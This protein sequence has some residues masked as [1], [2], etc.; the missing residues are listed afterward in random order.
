MADSTDQDEVSIKRTRSPTESDSDHEVA[1][2][3]KTKKK[4]LHN[5]HSIHALQNTHGSYSQ[6]FSRSMPEEF[7]PVGH[8]TR[9]KDHTTFDYPQRQLYLTLIEFLTASATK[10]TSFKKIVLIYVGD[11]ADLN[12]PVWAHLSTMFPFVYFVLYIKPLA[13]SSKQFE[14]PNVMIKIN[15]EVFNDETA[16]NLIEEYDSN[17]NIRLFVSNLKLEREDCK[18]ELQFMSL[19]RQWYMKLQPFKAMLNFRLHF[20]QTEK[21]A[22]EYLQGQ[23][24]FPIWSTNKS[25][26]T[27]LHVD[28]SAPTRTYDCLKHKSQLTHFYDIDRVQWYEHELHDQPGID[29]CYDCRAEIF[30]FDSYIQMCDDELVKFKFRPPLTVKQY[31]SQLNRLIDSDN[32]LFAIKLNDREYEIKFTDVSLGK[33]LG[34]LSLKP[35]EPATRSP[36][37][38]QYKQSVYVRPDHQLTR[39]LTP[40]F[41]CMKYRRRK[42][43]N[44]TTVHFGQ[45]K[46]L[47]SEI[48]FLTIVCNEFKRDSA[49]KFV[50]VYAGAA[51]GHHTP[52]LMNMFP[53]MEYVLVDPAD[54]KLD[55]AKLKYKCKYTIKQEFFTDEMA[56]QLRKDYRDYEILFISDIRTANYRVLTDKDTEIKVEQ[57]MIDQM[58]WYRILE[59][60]KAMLKFRL[61]Y[62]DRSGKTELEYLKG[63]IYFQVWEG[64]TSSETRLVV[65]KNAGMQVYDCVKYEDQLFRFNTV[66][67]VLCYAHDI[68]ARGIDHC[69][70]CRA[71]I[72][73]LEEYLKL[74]GKLPSPANHQELETSVTELVERI[75][76]DLNAHNRFIQLE[77]N[78]CYYNI[79]FTD[80]CLGKKESELF[81]ESNKER[82]NPFGKSF[83]RTNDDGDNNFTAAKCSVQPG[84]SQLAGR[85]NFDTADKKRQ[86][87]SGRYK[88]FS[89]YWKK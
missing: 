3:K 7:T 56:S 44:K 53:F 2:E 29:A 34:D 5:D 31:I 36:H 51:P 54:F 39:V 47:V 40:D 64:C 70:D 74:K 72:H 30:I 50:V 86:P 55:E 73:I 9:T 60:L 85:L 79:R 76:H 41:P 24:N 57:D 75:N 48:E 42:G 84:H 16:L 80:M 14:K 19:Q 25:Y 17:S 61:P 15:R 8:E 20:I 28:S 43:E 32:K 46:L 33:S 63:D 22:F 23:L 89:K 67:R 78:G 77:F 87:E 83:N 1:V 66:E 82:G 38:L 13:F 11:E 49:S 52:T 27:Q 21:A 12:E 10:L 69:Y 26:Q 6:S 45:R 88:K 4:G 68:E 65:G 18:A 81:V 62:V 71:E 58:N 35:I 59:P 37:T